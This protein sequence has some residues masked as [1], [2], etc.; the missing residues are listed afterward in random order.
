M[1]NGA[2]ERAVKLFLEGKIG[3]FDIYRLLKG[4]FDSF[5]GIEVKD[6][7]DLV[8]ADA[9]GRDYVDGNFGV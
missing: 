8:E 4:A 9:F 5:K 2:S 1:I 6:F 3:F 7:S